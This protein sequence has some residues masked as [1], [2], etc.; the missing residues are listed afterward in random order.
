MI[1]DCFAIRP[2]ANLRCCERVQP[3]TLIVCLIEANACSKR[4]ILWTKTKHHRKTHD[5]ARHDN[6]RS[7]KQNNDEAKE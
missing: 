1:P 6:R 7:E 2:T 5:T 3:L 4:R